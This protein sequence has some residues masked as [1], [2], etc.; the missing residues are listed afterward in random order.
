M[1]GMLAKFF[2]STAHGCTLSTTFGEDV[3]L[4][5]NRMEGEIYAGFSF[6]HSAKREQDMREMLTRHGLD[7]PPTSTKDI[8]FPTFI[9]GAPVWG[10]YD[11]RPIPP[12]RVK[13][14]TLFEDLFRAMTN[15]SEIS[16]GYR[17]YEFRRK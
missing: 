6:I 17:F 2:G 10:A 14:K 15:T 13:R 5:L 7:Q 12:E 4:V 16:L 9:P 11:L 3:S 8:R 1:E